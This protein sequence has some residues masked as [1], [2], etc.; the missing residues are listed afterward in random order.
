[1]LELGGAERNPAPN[2]AVPPRHHRPQVPPHDT[3][4]PGG[5]QGGE[6]E[7][8]SRRK[9][10]AVGKAHSGGVRGEVPKSHN[11][12]SVNTQFTVSIKGG[13]G[14]E[15]LAGQGMPRGVDP[16]GSMGGGKGAHVG[17]DSSVVQRK[18]FGGGG[19]PL[20]QPG[21][22][23]GGAQSAAA[24]TGLG[25]GVGGPSLPTG[26]CPPRGVQ[27]GWWVGGQ[28]GLPPPSRNT[29]RPP[30]APIPQCHRGGVPAV[31]P[32]LWHTVGGG[33]LGLSAGHAPIPPLLAGLVVPPRRLVVHRQPLHRV[34]GERLWDKAERWAPP[35]DPK[36]SP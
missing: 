11:R 5:P 25:G 15:S 19:D 12:R 26:L 35:P 29:P 17:E 24:Q 23:W 7:A 6:T 18:E 1:M 21:L 9:D 31:P 34:R 8:R 10:L 16:L 3:P 20:L 27:R 14:A 36:G 13:G 32:A 33:V 28:R 4:I 2:L 30:P 22:C